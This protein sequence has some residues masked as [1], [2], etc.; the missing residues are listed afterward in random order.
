MKRDFT[1]TDYEMLLKLDESVENR[2]GAKKKTIENLPTF[3]IE[4]QEQI[5][6]CCVC[7]NEMEIGNIVRKLPCEHYFHVECIDKWLERKF[8]SSNI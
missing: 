1:D 5:T 3:T 6:S 2:K 8:H 7:L 4:N